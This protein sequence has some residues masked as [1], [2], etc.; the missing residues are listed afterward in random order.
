MSVLDHLLYPL[1]SSGSASP[2]PPP[3]SV[4][5]FLSFPF[6]DFC[7]AAPVQGEAVQRRRFRGERGAGGLQAPAQRQ[8][9]DAART[10]PAQQRRQSLE[11]GSQVCAGSLHL[12][13]LLILFGESLLILFDVLAG[14]SPKR[15]VEARRMRTTN[16]RHSSPPSF[17]TVRKGYL[18]MHASHRWRWC[19]MCI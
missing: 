19:G 8:E 5:R 15:S 4:S 2:L 7:F 18:A 12:E 17:S 9:A 6:F 13:S 10:L 16:E 11:E 3:P 14:N 1:S